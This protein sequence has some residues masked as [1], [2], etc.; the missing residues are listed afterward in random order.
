M[1]RR[2]SI[3]WSTHTKPDGEYIDLAETL[4]IKVRIAYHTALF[5]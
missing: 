3:D 2:M 4:D 1:A 5:K